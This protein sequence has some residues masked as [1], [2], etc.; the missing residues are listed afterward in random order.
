MS[1]VLWICA[2]SSEVC[3]LFY[4]EQHS[5]HHTCQQSRP[6]WAS[7]EPQGSVEHTAQSRIYCWY[8]ALAGVIVYSTQSAIQLMHTLF[9]L[10]LPISSAWHKG[11]APNIQSMYKKGKHHKH[12]LREY[13]RE[14]TI[15]GLWLLGKYYDRNFVI[16][17]HLILTLTHLR[18][19]ILFP[20]YR[21]WN[22]DLE[23]AKQQIIPAAEIWT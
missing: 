15:P 7:R 23:R 10:Y 16:L 12:T 20:P 17:V 2:K 18:K 13:K 21:W 6:H 4:T 19:C 3:W 11:S 1:V 5:S 14:L 9:H 8:S 22:R